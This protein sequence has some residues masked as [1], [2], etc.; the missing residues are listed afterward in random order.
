[1]S[2]DLTAFEALGQ[3][4]GWDPESADIEELKGGLTNRTYFVCQDGRQCVLRLDSLQST[5]F[6]FD[7]SAELAI[8][9]AAHSAGIAP[10]VIYADPAQSILVTEFLEGRTW[11]EADLDEDANIEALA[12]VLRQVHALE[13]E[14]EPIDV[15]AAARTYEK[16]LHR[17]QGLYS[18]ALKCVEIVESIAPRNDLSC[19]HNDIVAANVIENDSLKLID[20]E[21]SCVH[22]RFF[23]LAS[24]IGFHNLDEKRAS[25]LLEA[26]T[27]GADGEDRERLEEQVR[28]YDA[29]QWL[30]LATRQLLFPNRWQA[31][32]LEELQ[33]RIR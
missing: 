14:V 32:R 25:A 3:V 13:I 30:W 22:D 7:R 2:K 15:A 21:F 16:Y 5:M 10:A 1:M 9:E 28:V 23:D 24:A 27:G 6:Q 33:Q 4:P 19:C 8:L 31:R 11:E 12:D 26:Y 29:V 18:F 17:R 20:W